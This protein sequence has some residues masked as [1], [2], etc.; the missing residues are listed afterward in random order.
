MSR[1]IDV[2]MLYFFIFS[3]KNTTC[4]SQTN[5]INFSVLSCTKMVESHTKADASCCTSH[6]CALLMMPPKI[7][8]NARF[9][10]ELIRFISGLFQVNSL[11][12]KLYACELTIAQALTALIKCSTDDDDTQT[13]HLWS[14]IWTCD[15]QT[16]DV[17]HQATLH[18]LKTVLG[19]FVLHAFSVRCLVILTWWRR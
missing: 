3:K 12:A 15:N 18:A 11:R 6:P 4:A 14:L 8:E 5:L 13:L 17:R 16:H 2:P 1:I 10:Q 19:T 9:Q 7:S